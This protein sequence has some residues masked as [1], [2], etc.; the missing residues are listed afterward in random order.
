MYAYI[1][2]IAF[3]L[4]C[5]GIWDVNHSKDTVVW[6][7][8][9]ATVSLFRIPTIADDEHYIR[10]APTDNFK[11]IV[12]LEFIVN[13]Y[14]FSLAIEVFLVPLI[15]IISAML[16]YAENKT[17]TCLSMKL[18]KAAETQRMSHRGFQSLCHIRVRTVQLPP[19]SL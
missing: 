18:S 4:Y 9:A 11:I 3:L 14:T 8:S 13:V 19:T 12:I 6:S 10:N 2:L 16:V 5:V 15:A 1:A 7:V 17:E